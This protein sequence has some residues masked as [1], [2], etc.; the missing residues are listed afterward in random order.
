MEVQGYPNYLIYEDGKIFSKYKNNFIKPHINSE[1]YYHKN[2]YKNNNRKNHSIHRLI[3]I[4]YIPNPEN[5]R[6]V[7]HINR[8]RSDNRIENLR[9]VTHS[10]NMQNKGIRIDNTSG[11]KYISYNT[12]TDRWVF[13]KIINGKLTCKYFKTKE[14][15][16]EFKNQ[17]DLTCA[18][19]VPSAIIA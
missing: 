13:R 3:A 19:A 4:H 16:I 14:E 7:D 1:G 10:E 18:P 9:W 12:R 17:L 8:D 15:A 11:V 2:L 5:K 6:E